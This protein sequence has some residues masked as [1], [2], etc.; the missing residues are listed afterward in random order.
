MLNFLLL[1]MIAHSGLT[2]EIPLF[3]VQFPANF[4]S[5]P[6][7][8]N[9]HPVRLLNYSYL[10]GSE[11]QFHRI[12]LM[13]EWKVA[14]WGLGLRGEAGVADIVY[15]DDEEKRTLPVLDAGIFWY[16]SWKRVNLKISI[17]AGIP[18]IILPSVTLGL[19]MG[20]IEKISLKIG[21][22]SSLTLHLG[23]FDFAVMGGGIDPG[24]G[25]AGGLRL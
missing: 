8:G 25:I 16:H 17:A 12:S 18:E 19:K 10:R 1:L 4:L 13:G 23:I 11:T 3:D 20:G 22:I 15:F 14:S 9:A 24:L 6:V 5:D 7:V 21:L 2:I